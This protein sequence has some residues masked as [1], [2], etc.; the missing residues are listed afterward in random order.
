[1]FGERE[2]RR[3]V[4]I[5]ETMARE[6]WPGADAVGQ[7]ILIGAHLGPDFEEGPVEIIGVVADTRQGGLEFETRA[8]MYQLHSQIPDA[9][10]KMVNGLM[11]AAVLLRTQPGVPPTSVSKAVERL[12]LSS[13]FQLPPTKIRTMDQVSLNSTARQNFNTVLL[14]VFAGIA[15]LLAAVGIY[16]VMS[17]A[18]EQRTHEIGIR[19]ALGATGRDTLRLVLGEGM[20]L[21]LIGV[22]AGLAAA[23][24]LTRLIGAQLLASNPPIRS[25]LSRSRRFCFRS[26]SWPVAF[27][28]SEPA[29]WTRL[30]PYGMSKRR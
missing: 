18:V 29:G 24:G 10:M 6:F 13:E 9:A 1:M 15:L 21:A 26:R 4:I 22:L 17:Y 23:F 14:G 3:T 8:A 27:R 19:A 2:P 30:S 12:L 28:R 7:T 25:H 5:N 16:G 11:P 20:R